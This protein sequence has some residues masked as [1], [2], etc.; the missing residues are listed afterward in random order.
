MLGAKILLESEIQVRA[1]S[2]ERMQLSN[3]VHS[4]WHLSPG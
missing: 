1:E 2:S 4:K 3:S